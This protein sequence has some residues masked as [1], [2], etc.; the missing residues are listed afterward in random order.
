MAIKD[1]DI[2]LY[3]AFLNDAIN[4]L[5]PN[6]RE[7]YYIFNGVAS[8]EIPRVLPPTINQSYLTELTEQLHKRT[9]R[10]SSND[11]IEKWIDLLDQP[12]LDARTISTE[13]KNTEITIQELIDLI[14]P[15]SDKGSQL[16]AIKG[17]SG[18]ER[19]H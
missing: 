11:V 16:I 3:E 7:T 10:I 14:S 4:K 8:S 17:N 1:E 9:K 12:D 6:E 19:Q 18:L 13:D 15:T 2:A 5:E